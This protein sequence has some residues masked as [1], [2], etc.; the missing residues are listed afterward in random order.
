MLRFNKSKTTKV[1]FTVLSVCMAAV[2][3]TACGSNKDAA[4]TATP[5]ASASPAASAAATA[6]PAPAVDKVVKDSMGHDVKVP[7][8][9]KAVIASYLEDPLLALGVK[10]IVQ[11]SVKGT[12][13]QDYLQTQLAGI[14]TIGYEL[15]VESVL[16][17]SPDFMIVGSESAVEKGLYDQYSKVVPTF[18]LGSDVTADFRKTLLKM[19]EL[20]NKTDAANAALKKYD[21]QV[22]DT[23][24]KLASTVGDKKVAILWLTNKAFYVVN[25]KVASGAVVYG[26]LGLKMPN[27]LSVLPDAPANWAAISL[28]KLAQLDADYIFLVNSD[29][30]QAGNLEDPLWK[31]IPAVKSGK[32]FEMDTKSS[33]LYNGVIAGERVMDDIVK[34]IK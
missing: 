18:V 17:A 30:G 4:S 29:K 27:I 14:P 12:T 23:K 33:W 34:V 1:T 13:V 20:L 8:N 19:G 16:K 32:V 28:E 10:P 3:A 2:L 21:Q 25:G 22:T 24:A 5:A 6:T 9:P 11:W 7:A 15:P 31:N 26:D